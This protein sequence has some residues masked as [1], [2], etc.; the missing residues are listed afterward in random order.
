[1]NNHK[2]MCRDLYLYYSENG[3]CVK[4]G[5]AFSLA[6]HVLCGDCSKKA[7]MTQKKIDPDGSKKRARMK[8]LREQRKANGICVTCGKNP[9]NPPH[10]SCRKCL[11]AD[12]ERQ[13]LKRI[14]KKVRKGLI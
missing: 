8:E 7:N 4:C 1:M 3:I 9:V 6:G 14:R 13:L 10:T 12:K 2:K 11:E 5:Q